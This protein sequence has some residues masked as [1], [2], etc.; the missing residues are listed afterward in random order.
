MMQLESHLFSLPEIRTTESL[1]VLPPVVIS[2][3]EVDHVTVTL[4]K[5]QQC[6]CKDCG[7]LFNSVWYLKQHAVKHSN[8]R[9]FRC[10]FCFKTY[11]FRSNLY[12]HK[13]P[14]RVK[15]VNARQRLISRTLFTGQHSHTTTQTSDNNAIQATTQKMAIAS[16]GFHEQTFRVPGYGPNI[17]LLHLGDSGYPASTINEAISEV[18]VREEK[19]EEIAENETQKIITTRKKPLEQAFIDE[20]IQRYKHKLFQCRKCRIQFPSREYLSRHIAYH[21]ETELLSHKC[22]QCPQRF[23]TENALRRH[24]EMHSSESNFKCRQCTAHFRSML[25]L[26]R[27]KDGCRQCLSPPFGVP[28][29]HIV[30]TASCAVDEYAFIDAVEAAALH[31]PLTILDEDVVGTKGTDSGLGSEGSNQSCATSPARSS[32]HLEEDEGFELESKRNFAPIAKIRITLNGAIVSTKKKDK[33]EDDE[34][35]YRSRLNSTTHSVSP[36]SASAFSVDSGSPTRKASLSNATDGTSSVYA[37]YNGFVSSGHGQHFTASRSYVNNG[38]TG[39]ATNF[40]VNLYEAVDDG[41]C[42][43]LASDTVAVFRRNTFR[44]RLIKPSMIY[45]TSSSNLVELSLQTLRDDIH[46]YK[47]VELA[48]TQILRSM[49]SCL[50]LTALIEAFCELKSPS[51]DR[52]VTLN[53]SRASSLLEILMPGCAR[54]APKAIITSYAMKLPEKTSQNNES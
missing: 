24:L 26:R 10:K 9:P 38:M 44:P 34:S 39:R 52:G 3:T 28:V 12:Q 4:E 54:S 31:S 51:T 47:A 5:N 48:R 49:T 40:S 32:V 6:A 11:K 13:C 20:Y 19:R 1:A 46:L 42:D 29:D 36:A 25:A 53:F 33:E 14:D 7:K 18:N 16:N 21:T 50:L 23:G 27:H 45:S 35:G 37:H 22:L 41:E 8:D 15:S 2:P 43:H 30:Q 17:S